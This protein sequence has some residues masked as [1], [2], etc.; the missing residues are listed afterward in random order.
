MTIVMTV[1]LTAIINAGQIPII[2]NINPSVSP[3]IAKNAAMIALIAK[4][5]PKTTRKYPT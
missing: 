4:R 2:R 5:S 1:T 3:I